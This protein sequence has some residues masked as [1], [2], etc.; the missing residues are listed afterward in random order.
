MVSFAFFAR[1]HC[2]VL[3]T[4]RELRLGQNLLTGPIPN[5]I[6]FMEGL[7]ILSLSQNG[8]ESPLPP[9][10]VLLSQ[11]SVLDLSAAAFT[12]NFPP[13]YTT[14]L[15]LTEMNLSGNRLAGQL[16]VSGWDGLGTLTTLDLSGNQFSGSIPGG[17]A[18]AFNLGKADAARTPRFVMFAVPHSYILLLLF[19]CTYL[20]S[21]LIYQETMVFPVRFR[22]NTWL[23]RIF[24]FCRWA[25]I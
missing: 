7:Q 17:I 23:Y 5:T 8:F 22:L 6:S 3:V 13:E 14:F 11:L 25:V 19:I 21:V 18:G 24:A 15:A 9:E 1:L 10:L 2:S 4:L 16:P 12:G 20:Q